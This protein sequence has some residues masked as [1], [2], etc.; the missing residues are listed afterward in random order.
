MS[1]D[2]VKNSPVFAD[3]L[4]QACKSFI[5]LA[6]GGVAMDSKIDAPKRKVDSVQFLSSLWS[7]YT[8]P[9]LLRYH[10]R[11]LILILYG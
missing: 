3:L 10:Y 5:A 7:L 11:C 2:V 4:I 1:T 6:T 9:S 8:V